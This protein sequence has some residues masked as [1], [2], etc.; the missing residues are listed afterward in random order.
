VGSPEPVLSS[1]GGEL[2]YDPAAMASGLM[3]IDDATSEIR[4]LLST[5][6]S[7]V[8]ALGATWHARSNIAFA[9]VHA[10][11]SERARLINAALQTMHDKLSA[12]DVAYARTEQAQIEQYQALA[13]SI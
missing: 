2:D 10:K 8:D 13:N 7:E 3:A 11:W 5:I 1:G 4:N 6:Q 9:Q 12:T